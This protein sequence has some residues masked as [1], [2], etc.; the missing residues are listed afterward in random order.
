M[1]NK[2]AA[3]PIHPRH[4]DVSCIL[5]YAVYRYTK[6]YKLWYVYTVYVDGNKTF[7]IFVM[8]NIYTYDKPQMDGGSYI[9]RHIRYK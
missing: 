7:H 5:I 6:I 3:L 1:Y 8:I 4:T 2:V 9:S